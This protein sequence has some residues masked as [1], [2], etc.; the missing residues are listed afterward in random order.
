MYPGLSDAG[1]A[2]RWFADRPQ[3]PLHWL[4]DGCVA[5][6]FASDGRGWMSALTLRTLDDGIQVT[7][8]LRVNLNQSC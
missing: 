7:D 1:F 3:A 6:L 8:G 4:L 2:G 5:E